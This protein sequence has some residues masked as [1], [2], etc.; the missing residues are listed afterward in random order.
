MA[1][2]WGGPIREAG[3]LMPCGEGAWDAARINLFVVRE[4]AFTLRDAYA[5]CAPAALLAT[6]VF[7]YNLA[8]EVEHFGLTISFF[9]PVL[10]HVS[11]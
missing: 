6:V 9:R 5:E 11:A 2:L 8:G 7:L 1:P 4:P 3:S 10:V